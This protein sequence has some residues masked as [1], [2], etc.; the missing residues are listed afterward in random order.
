LNAHAAG[1]TAKPDAT[2]ESTCLSSRPEVTPSAEY[3]ACGRVN[4]GSTLP[5]M[6]PHQATASPLLHRYNLDEFFA[7]DRPRAGG[8]HELI[9]GVL[10]IV[11]PPS[12]AHS[13]AASR[14]NVIF[15]KYIAKYPKRCQLFIPRSPIWSAADT[16][17]E[18]DMFLIST[19]HLKN[20]DPARLTTADL[21]VEVMSPATAVY[22]RTA[23]ADTYRGLG[24]RE[25]WLVDL[26]GRTIEQR[27]LRG[28]AWHVAGVFGRH[29]R[30]TARAFDGLAVGIDQV[31][32]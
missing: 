19:H 24:V 26:E 10:Y 25:L 22:D 28:R 23:K 21:V 32:A 27:V 16:Y 13:I 11:P 18:P 12:G 8:H 14:L 31:F 20:M 4:Q 7:L 9:A 15:A 5:V 2:A 1:I 29:T 6:R 3:A 17:L 30:V